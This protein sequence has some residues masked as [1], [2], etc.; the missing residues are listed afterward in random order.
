MLHW[1]ITSPAPSVSDL[2]AKNPELPPKLAEIIVRC[3]SKDL[4]ERYA[5][6]KVRPA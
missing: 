3:L 1:Q 5:S 6:T 2:V 4:D